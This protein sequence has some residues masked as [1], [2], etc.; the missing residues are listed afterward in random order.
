M[1]CQAKWISMIRKSIKF[2]SVIIIH[3]TMITL[4]ICKGKMTEKE[5]YADLKIC[6]C[7]TAVTHNRNNWNYFKLQLYC[8]SQFFTRSWK[9]CYCDVKYL[10]VIK[11]LN[12]KAYRFNKA[13]L[14]DKDTWKAFKPVE[15]F[16]CVTFEQK[17]FRGRFEPRN[18]DQR[19]FWEKKLTPSTSNHFFLKTNSLSVT[20]WTLSTDLLD[21]FSKTFPPE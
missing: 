11:N 21:Q 8:S 4:G 15:M 3:Q 7:V 14:L 12:F 18:Y 5:Y 13:L 20:P 1:V 16:N 9:F 19:K 10:S 17:N 6:I 2:S